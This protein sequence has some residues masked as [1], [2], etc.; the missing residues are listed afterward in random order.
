MTIVD[1]SV[2]IDHLRHSIRQL[3][4]LLA[5]EQVLTHPFVI[6]EL[7]C[8]ELRQRSQILGL[9]SQLPQAAVA[10]HEETLAFVE[11]YRLMG[12]GIGWIDAH[13]LCSTMLTGATL[14]TIDRRLRGT[15]R[16]LGVAL[17]Q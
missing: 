1:T 2:W 11:T 15:A 7:A 8:G 16:A 5:N 10:T 13:L 14:W 9:L 6:G 17:N 3:E 4:A 12:S